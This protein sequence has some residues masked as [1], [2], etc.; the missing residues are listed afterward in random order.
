MEDPYWLL[1]KKERKEA[2]KNLVKEVNILQKDLHH[3]APGQD[4]RDKSDLPV[5]IPHPQEEMEDPDA[6]VMSPETPPPIRMTSTPS[7]ATRCQWCCCL[8][9]G[10]PRSLSPV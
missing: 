7:E 1:T 5:P 9:R 3:T 8:L 10:P 6:W 2:L 4:L